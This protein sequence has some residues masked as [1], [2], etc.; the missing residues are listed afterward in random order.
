MPHSEAEV[1]QAIGWLANIR[2][3]QGL[4]RDQIV[5]LA[6]ELTVRSFAA[7]ETIAS[8]DDPVTEF[9]I[10]VEGE[11]DSILTDPRGREEFLGIVHQGETVGEIYILE[12]NPNRPARFTARTNGKLLVAPAEALIRWVKIYPSLMQNLFF[13]LSERFKTVT[14]AAS[15]NVPSPRLGIVASS[16]LG[17]EL[18]GKIVAKLLKVGERL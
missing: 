13:T 15:R 8:P 1:E 11:L 16:K 2:F 7:G 14:G 10:V 12:K 3:C 4:D 6:Q 5:S 17:C 9:W 18:A